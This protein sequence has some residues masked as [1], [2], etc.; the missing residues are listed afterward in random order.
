MNYFIN[1]I[2]NLYLNVNIHKSIKLNEIQKEF[3]KTIYD[4]HGIYLKDKTVITFDIVK[5][6][7]YKLHPGLIVKLIKID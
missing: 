1:K 7:I 5:N 2:H 6:Y 4:L 3:R